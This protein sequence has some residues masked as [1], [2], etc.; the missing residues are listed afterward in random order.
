MGRRFSVN[1]A[2]EPLPSQSIIPDIA[3]GSQKL[4]A[5]KNRHPTCILLKISL[6]AHNSR[7]SM[8]HGSTASF[9]SA[10]TGTPRRFDLATYLQGDRP[11][12]NATCA[13]ARGKRQRGTA[14]GTAT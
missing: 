9:W 3:F 14:R 5:E 6:F 13:P 8:E 12:K 11:G 2:V 7:R 1:Y 4:R 10:G